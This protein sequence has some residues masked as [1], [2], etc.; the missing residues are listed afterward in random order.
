M[1]MSYSE[2]FETYSIHKV[3]GLLNPFTLF[4]KLH[5]SV[6]ITKLASH[7]LKFLRLIARIF[8]M[9]WVFNTISHIISKHLCVMHPFEFEKQKSAKSC[10][11]IVNRLVVVLV[12]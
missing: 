5:G 1:N 6:F 8:L 10:L 7:V 12:L 11:V 4:Q 9:N 2:I 3:Y